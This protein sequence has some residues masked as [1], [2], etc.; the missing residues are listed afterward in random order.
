MKPAPAALQTLRY[1]SGCERPQ[2][3]SRSIAVAVFVG[4]LAMAPWSSAQPPARAGM[5][6]LV[7]TW[8]LASVQ[9]LNAGGEPTAVPNPRGLLVYDAA[10]H[11][12]E[13]VTRGNR[14]PYAAGQATPAEAQVTLASFGGFWGG[15]RVD[16]QQ[17]TITYRM[18]GAVNPNLMGQEE[19]RSYEL[20]GDRLMV[21]SLPSAANGQSGTRWTWQRIPET[22]SLSP[23]YRRLVGFWQHVVEQRVHPT[24]GAVLTETRRA[25]S[26]IVY[27]PSGYVGVHFPPL[28]RKRF[29]GDLPTDEEA[30]AAIGGYVGYYGVYTLYPGVVFHHRLAILSPPTSQ[31]DTL[32]RFFEI[33]G[34]QITLKFPP[35][36]AQGQEQRTVVKLKRLSGDAEM[37]R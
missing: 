28:N 10:G 11:A 31:G 8:T 6:D 18:D 12:L 9:R 24:T 13:I 5:R 7:G 37:I 25:P 34:D 33:A 21:S 22:E 14:A 1:V 29:A 4:L 17:A 3:P 2:M 20:K 15:Y 26:V 16:A 36:V 32:Q 27:T 30:R 23:A 35:G 19:T